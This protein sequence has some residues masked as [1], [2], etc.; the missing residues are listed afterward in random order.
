[1][2]SSR[3][4]QSDLRRDER[5][6]AFFEL[7]VVFVPL[8]T[9]A[10]CV[11]QLA[12]VA[13]ADLVVQHAADSA[14]RSAV[15][16]LPDDPTV[17][18]GEPQMSS[19]GQRLQAIR[20]AAATPLTPLSP[21][22][23]TPGSSP[24]LRG[25]LGDPASIATSEVYLS[26]ALEVTFPSATGGTVVGPEVTVRVSYLYACGVPLA[27]RLVCTAGEAG[28]VEPGI[29][30]SLRALAARRTGGRHRR[31]VHERT[32]MVHEAPYTYRSQGA[33]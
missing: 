27:R 10:L 31:I 33:S 30:A 24:T 1:M 21:R 11:L 18:D 12:L 25:A 13:Q 23:E 20:R 29:R 32:L 3:A 22:V 6:A 15:V 26:S 14:A 28:A 9:F 2:R 4:K 7:L 17:Y 8:W 16:V 19:E 5:G